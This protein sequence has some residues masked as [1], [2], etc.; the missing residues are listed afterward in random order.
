MQQLI[1]FLVEIGPLMVFFA[2]YFIADDL[3][4]ATGVF[5]GATV[6]ALIYAKLHQGRVPP[7]LLI[8]ALIVT[9]FGGL[10]IALDNEIFIKMKPTIVYCIFS[11]ILLGGLAM[12]RTWIAVLFGSSFQLTDAGWRV[13]TLRWGV[14]FLVMAA[15]N[16]AVWRNVSTDLWVTLKVFGFLPLTFIFALAQTPLML[17]HQIEEDE[18]ASPTESDKDA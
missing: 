8:S 1:K 11:V 10:T 18:T 2:G 4:V 14:F 3:I 16:E 12:G 7:M 5:M 17:R 6:A 13:M 15:L 9:V